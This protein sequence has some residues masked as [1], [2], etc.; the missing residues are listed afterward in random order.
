VRWLALVLLAASAHASGRDAIGELPEL[1]T[2][3]HG[4]A[5]VVVRGDLAKARAREAVQLVDQ[6]IADVE[7]RFTRPAEHADAPVTLCVLHDDASYRD[8]A[9]TLG[10]IPSPWGFYRPDRRVAIANFGQSIGNLRH[11]LVHPLIG[12]DFPEIPAWLNEGVAAL[13]GTARPTKRGFEFLVNYRLRDLQ[14]AL[15]KGE[16]PSIGELA[17]STDADIRGPRAG[18]YY[19]YARYVL[20]FLDRKGKLDA[21]Y[22]ALRDA[23]GDVAKQRRILE[24]AVD[25]HAFRAWARG[26]RY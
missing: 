13:Y 6:V 14:R 23:S 9:G 18:M 21:T 3:E 7:R 25:E 12:D 22:A 16:L 24:A 17:E 5:R 26:L 1:G 4:R 8:V 15:A 19:A 20:L 10:D 2:I 11:E